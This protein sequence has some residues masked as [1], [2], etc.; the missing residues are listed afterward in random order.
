M[1]GLKK[2]EIR[3]M[4]MVCSVAERL[5]WLSRLYVT[6]VL[7]VGVHKLSLTLST[8]S[9]SVCVCVCVLHMTKSTT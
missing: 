4:R 8:H 2:A 6:R 3:M 9:H 1:Q 7:P 5:S